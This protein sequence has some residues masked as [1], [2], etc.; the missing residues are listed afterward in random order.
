MVTPCWRRQSVKAAK[1]LPLALVAADG[2]AA[3]VPLDDEDEPQPAANSSAA[4]EARIAPPWKIRIR[5]MLV[6]H[7]GTCLR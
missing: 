1:P 6:D 5:R 4:V 2:G 7:P 3:A